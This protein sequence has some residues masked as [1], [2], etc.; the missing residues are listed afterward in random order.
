MRE[1][2]VNGQVQERDEPVLLETIL[3]IGLVEAQRTA[4]KEKEVSQV[5]QLDKGC[6][7]G[8]KFG[9]ALFKSLAQLIVENAVILYSRLLVALNNDCNEYP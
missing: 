9:P 2:I 4:Q 5:A 6:T 7:L 3:S 1:T 8:I